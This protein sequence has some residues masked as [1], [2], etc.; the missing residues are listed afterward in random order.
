M[1][2]RFT[3]IELLVVIAIIAILAS[4]LLP[5]LQKAKG[6]ANS[7][8]CANHLKQMVTAEA[9]YADEYDELVNKS[10]TYDF[11]RPFPVL[12]YPYLNTYDIF[13]CPCDIDPQTY[14]V[15]TSY[16]CNYRVHPPWDYA[17]QR[18]QK[19]LKPAEL[20][21]MAENGDGPNSESSVGGDGPSSK[22]GISWSRVSLQRH[23]NNSNYSF[24]DGHVAAM[25]PGEA[26][27]TSIHWSNG[28]PMPPYLN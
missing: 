9:M 28:T 5:S 8:S 10:N 25:T 19:V 11:K 12:L 14:T 16:I 26:R 21:S 3:L 18:L 7:M 1:R 2:A 4:M 23:G 27:L 15:K 20:I 6:K 17:N 24:M 13:L 22:N